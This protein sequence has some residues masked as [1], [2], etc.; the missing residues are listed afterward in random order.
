LRQWKRR[1]DPD[2]AA[3]Q[4]VY[5]LPAT[6]HRFTFRTDDPRERPSYKLYK[7]YECG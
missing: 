3:N 7:P 2:P 4:A 1:E 6:V 5:P